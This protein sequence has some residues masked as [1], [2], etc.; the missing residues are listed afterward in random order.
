M[1]ILRREG[2]RFALIAG[3]MTCVTLCF[4]ANARAAFHQW[5]FNELFSNADGTVQFIEFSNGPATGEVFMTSA[6]IDSNASP[7]YH[8]DHNLP[9]TANT[10][11]KKLL[12]ATSGFVA[13]LPSVPPDYILPDNFFSI[14]GDT[15]VFSEFYDTF[16]FGG[17]PTDGVMSLN[18]NLSN[19]HQ[20]AHQFRG[21]DRRAQFVERPYPATPTETAM[22]TSLTSI[23]FRR[24]GT[25][26]G[27][28]RT[29]MTTTS[30]TFSTSISFLRIG[31]RRPPARRCPSRRAA[32]WL[33]WRRAHLA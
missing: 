14:T 6:T 2:T 12:V 33:F 3:T 31:T 23:S 32:C 29:S 27:R 19:R 15:L 22:S 20:L 30:S 1:T 21:H 11:N 28:K 5:V 7:T 8:F 18:R 9:L 25:R 17:V 4:A 26:P 24:N 10:A 16:T 13:A